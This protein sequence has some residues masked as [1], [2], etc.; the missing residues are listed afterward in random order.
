[1]KDM[2]PGF[3]NMMQ[4]NEDYEIRLHGHTNG[5]SA[6]KIIRLSDDSRDYF[7]LDDSSVEGWG[8]AKQL[9]T[10]RAE[11]IK[12]YLVDNGIDSKRI[13]VKGWGGK[14]M[15]Y[16]KNSSSAKKNIRVEV[17]VLKD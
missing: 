1:M 16:D 11:T 5:N 3:L 4:E 12:R 7:T 14:Q 10:D 6:G 13:D 8:S 9:S 2:K 15:I 17:E